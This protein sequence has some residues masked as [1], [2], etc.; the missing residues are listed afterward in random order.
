MLH[1][2]ASS[3]QLVSA[4]P[5][6][7]LTTGPSRAAAPSLQYIVPPL[8]LSD[9]SGKIMQM[10][11]TGVQATSQSATPQLTG[12]QLAALP[13]AAIQLGGGPQVL[14][15]CPQSQAQQQQQQLQ[16]SPLSSVVPVMVAAGS[17]QQLA[18][19]K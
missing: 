17:S 6:A 10:V 15:L 12:F 4:I 13:R 8:A 19:S 9:A 2:S 1:P 18:V 16:N 3:F 7:H 5:A 14:M 11:S